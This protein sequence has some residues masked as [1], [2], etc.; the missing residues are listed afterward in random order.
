LIRHAEAE[1]NLYRRVHGQYDSLVTER[2][3]AQISELSRRF[4]KV[5][6]DAVYSSDLYRA[7]KTATAISV[8]KGLPIFA[9]TR[10]REIYMGV[11]EDRTFGDAQKFETEQLVYLN[12][13]PWKWQVEGSEA[14]ASVQ[15]RM[16]ETIREIAQRHDGGSVAV[17]SHGMALRA[18]LCG[19]L[20]VSGESAVSRVKHLD[21]TS[22]SRVEYS[23]GAFALKYYNDNSHLSADNST[24]GR[25]KWWR[26]KRGL[27]DTNIRFA[28]AAPGSFRAILGDAEC[29]FLELAPDLYAEEGV[30]LITRYRI[31]EGFRGIGLGVQLLGQ[32]ISVYRALGRS[33]VR[34][35]LASEFLKSAE[36][37]ERYGFES[38]APDVLEKDIR[39]PVEND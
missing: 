17:F 15:S 27:D 10:L 36:F 8:P 34:V 1:G 29:G 18:F 25:Q 30:G 39:I 24:L 9:D 6:I 26:D 20:G 13:D 12:N 28:Q 14:Y 7:R 2:G 19:V 32:T 22:V 11:W 37:F 5:H 16:T 33:R 23:G 3:K 4:D 35:A 21:N 31:V 38:T